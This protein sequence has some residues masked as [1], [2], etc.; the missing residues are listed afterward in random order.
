[1]VRNGTGPGL[2]PLRAYPAAEARGG[3]EWVSGEGLVMGEGGVARWRGGEG[4]AARAWA[5]CHGRC[6]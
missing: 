3:G 5:L 6:G 2:C 1:M 4:D